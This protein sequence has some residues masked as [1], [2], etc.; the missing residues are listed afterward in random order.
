MSADVN[1]KTLRHFYCRDALWHSFERMS[2]DFDRGSDELI[3]EAMRLFAREKG[4]LPTES[5]VRPAPVAPRP[6]PPAPVRTVPGLPPRQPAP[7]PPG[8]AGLRSTAH[9]QGGVRPAPPASTHN[10]GEDETT[11][12]PMMGSPASAP[13]YVIFENKKY[14]VDKE[15]FIIGRGSKSSDL[16]IRDGNVSRKHAAVIRRNGSYFMKDLGST[17]G[18]DFNGT[19]VDN[20]RIEEG[21]RYMICDY[22]IRFTYR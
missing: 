3:N 20:K 12:D 4:Y 18:V 6:T 13:L 9:F 11:P 2:E 17:N 21:D 10:R 7:P 8:A 16:A 14:L 22:E 1:R 5:E 15:Q 19:R